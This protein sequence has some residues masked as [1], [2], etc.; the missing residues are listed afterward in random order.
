[1]VIFLIILHRML[2][3]REHNDKYFA[4][5]SSVIKVLPVEANENL[6]GSFLNHFV[7]INLGIG[8]STNGKHVKIF[9]K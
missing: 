8:D 1:M 4:T 3:N 7:T 5:W 9:P 2:T 6:D